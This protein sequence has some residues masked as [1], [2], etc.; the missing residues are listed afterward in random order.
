[1]NRRF[2]QNGAK[3][4]FQSFRK[5]R[6][7]DPKSSN[8]ILTETNLDEILE[9]LASKLKE[10]KSPIRKYSE[11]ALRVTKDENRKPIKFLFPNAFSTDGKNS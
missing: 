8:E 6:E 4:P 5:D 2:C 11:P 10:D 7:G 9:R 1:M 3:P